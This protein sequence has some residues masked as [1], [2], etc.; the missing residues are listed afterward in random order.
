MLLFLIGELEGGE[1]WSSL[2][3]HLICKEATPGHGHIPYTLLPPHVKRTESLKAAVHINRNGRTN[4]AAQ[5]PTYHRWGQLSVPPQVSSFQLPWKLGSG[6]PTGLPHRPCWDCF[7]WPLPAFATL[8]TWSPSCRL[9][10]KRDSE[11]AFLFHAT[12]QLTLP[13]PLRRRQGT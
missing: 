9:G 5:M 3:P 12:A 7:K 1:S 13:E 10:D 2:V 4:P 11:F 8:L 6:S